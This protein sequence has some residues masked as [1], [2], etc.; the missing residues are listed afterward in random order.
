MGAAINGIP[1]VLTPAVNA[2]APKTGT[3]PGNTDFAPKKHG[4]FQKKQPPK[5]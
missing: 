1:T 4:F 3:A 2:P 5:M